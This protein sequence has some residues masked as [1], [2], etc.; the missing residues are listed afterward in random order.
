MSGSGSPPPLLL[1][2]T[3]AVLLGCASSLVKTMVGLKIE[4]VCKSRDLQIFGCDTE[5]M[6]NKKPKK[7]EREESCE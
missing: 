1:P 2:E 4:N 5:N 7:H 6:G 3:A